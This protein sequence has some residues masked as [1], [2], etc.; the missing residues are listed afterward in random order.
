M[1]I[2]PTGEAVS[3]AMYVISGLQPSARLSLEFA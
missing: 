1:A 3:G 2:V